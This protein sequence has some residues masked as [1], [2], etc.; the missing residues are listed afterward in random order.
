LVQLK[1][2]QTDPEILMNKFV[3]RSSNTNQNQNYMSWK[4]RFSA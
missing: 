2:L 4:R 3:L 1:T